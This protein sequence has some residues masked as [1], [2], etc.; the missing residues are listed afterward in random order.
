[1][2]AFTPLA[3]PGRSKYAN[4]TRPMARMTTPTVA[5]TSSVRYSVL[6]CASVMEPKPAQSNG[7]ACALSRK[8]QKRRWVHASRRV[9]RKAGATVRTHQR[10]AARAR[11]WRG[12]G[13]GDRG[14]DGKQR[15]GPAR[16]GETGQPD[17]DPRS[18]T[19]SPG[20]AQVPPRFGRPDLRP[21]PQRGQG[22]RHQGPVAHEQG[23]A[24]ESPQPL[25]GPDLDPDPPPPN[26]CHAAFHH[27]YRTGVVITLQPCLARLQ[28]E[29]IAARDR[30]QGNGNRRDHRRIG[31]LE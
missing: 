20:R 17:V 28:G 5:K 21:A 18:L 26:G 11:L 29:E 16:R 4:W 2:L 23:A 12:Q 22:T 8:N 3:S 30:S 10:R 1:M 14:S 24:G 27:G 7:F 15:A 19:W 31:A 9:E 13:G 25:T 6:S